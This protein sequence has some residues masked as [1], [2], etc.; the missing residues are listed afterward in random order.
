MNY[1]YFNIYEFI[2][3]NFKIFIFFTLIFI[4][5]VIKVLAGGNKMFVLAIIVVVIFVAPL[6]IISVITHYNSNN[7]SGP[8]LTKSVISEEIA[9]ISVR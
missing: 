8:L 6:I 1:H 5:E 4:K 3:N 2:F 9:L 7:G